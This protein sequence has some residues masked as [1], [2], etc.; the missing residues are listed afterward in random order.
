MFEANNKHQAT[1]DEARLPTGFGPKYKVNEYCVSKYLLSLLIVTIPNVIVDVPSL[2]KTVIK[3]LIV[4][5]QFLFSAISWCRGESLP[6]STVVKGAH[7]FESQATCCADVLA[8]CSEDRRGK[9][10]NSTLQTN[11]WCTLSPPT[12]TTPNTLHP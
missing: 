2:L 10:D 12:A 7:R 5:T 3:P 1:M 11:V 4:P 8:S 9:P 6:H